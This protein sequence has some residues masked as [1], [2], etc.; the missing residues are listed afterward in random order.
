MANQSI[1]ISLGRAAL[2]AGLAYIL[3]M[4][5]PFAEFLV[6]Q[7]LVITGNIAET[8]KNI[9]THQGLFISGLF[10]YLINFIGDLLAT[11]ALYI[12][13]KPVSEN[14]SLLTAW[15]R[16]AYTIISVAALL[17]LVT[18]LRLV[19]DPDYTTVFDPNQLHAQV[20]LYLNSFRSGWAFGFFFFDIHL[21]LLGYLTFKS[22]YIPKI[23]G[24]LLII[25]GF[26][27]M[28]DNLRPYLFPNAN[29]SFIAITFFGELVLMFWL[30]FKGSRIKDIQARAQLSQ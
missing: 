15:F 13:L 14:L 24:I 29:L 11:W 19:I 20:L 21:I 27:W 10:C 16:L 8:T 25:D 4:G 12:L 2:I 5:T 1:N 28:I 26:G 23:I 7:K 3:M 9:S 30:L 22:G 18:V 6:F 17:N